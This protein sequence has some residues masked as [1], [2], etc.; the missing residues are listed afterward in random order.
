MSELEYVGFWSRVWA[1]VLDSLLIMLV[2]SPVLYAIYGGKP[3]ALELSF[4]GAA[5]FLVS[6]VLPAAAVVWFW[7]NKQGTPGKMAIGARVVDATTGKSLTLRQSIGRYL[8]YFVS[9]I[10]F[11]LGLVWVGFD[12]RKQGWHDKLANT[13]VVRQ[14]P[15]VL[16][17]LRIFWWTARLNTGVPTV[18]PSA[19]PV[20]ATRF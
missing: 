19:F 17:G 12:G 3:S 4:A 1:T 14:R 6:C 5:D 10:P 2:T 20:D 15:V 8:A 13:V 7:I 11:G 16:L 9:I 18:H